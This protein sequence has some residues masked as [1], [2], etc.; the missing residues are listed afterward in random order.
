[1]NTDEIEAMKFTL[2][3]KK[4]KSKNGNDYYHRE[5]RFVVITRYEEDVNEFKGKSTYEI[6]GLEL[7]LMKNRGRNV[8][9][10]DGETFNLDKI[11]FYLSYFGTI[12][13][14]WFE[15]SSSNGIIHV[16]IYLEDENW[17]LLM[18][19]EEENENEYYIF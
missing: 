8:L 4:S 19:G 10:I 5:D 11:L 18:L 1:M 17:Y 9:M 12:G 16:K 15:F 6:S 3:L 2:N 14:I 7:V 13:A